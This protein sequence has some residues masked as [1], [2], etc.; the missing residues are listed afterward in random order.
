MLR[1]PAPRAGA[2]ALAAA[3]ALSGC[4]FSLQPVADFGGAANHVAVAYRPFVRGLNASCEERQRYVALEDAGAFDAAA[5][6]RDATAQCAPLRAD[7]ATAAL[8]GQALADY[9]SALAKL[10]KAKPTAFDGEIKGVGGAAAKLEGR[11]GTALFDAH[12]VSAATK[13]ARAA[14]AMALV[15]REHRLTRAELADN[16][17]ALVVVVAAMKTFAVSVYDGQLHET[18]EVM[19]GALRRLVAASTAPA[20]TDVQGRLPW[21]YAQSVAR[22]DLAANALESRHVRAFALAADDLVAAHAALVDN[23]DK[24]GGAQRLA[25]VAQFVQAAEA[26]DDEAAEL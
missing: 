14:A 9:A 2:V 25:L 17:E 12:A 13:I 6:E 7:A 16:H 1:F 3:A 8:F 11:D 24:L 19:E 26:I 21:R 18:R 20:Q 22:A 4:A 15:G 10:A 5:A 23:F